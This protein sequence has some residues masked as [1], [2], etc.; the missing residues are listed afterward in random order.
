MGKTAGKGW[1]L[2]SR[3]AWIAARWLALLVVLVGAGG[4]FA[5]E[6]GAEGTPPQKTLVTTEV[7]SLKTQDPVSLAEVLSKLAQGTA[8]DKE[9]KEE[10]VVIASDQTTRS[11]IVRANRENQEWIAKLIARLDKR[12]PQLLIDVTMVEITNHDRFDYDLNF[13]RNSAGLPGGRGA[14]VEL[15]LPGRRGRV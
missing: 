7:Y 9:G 8:Q 14:S 5:T 6:K 2:E 4:A 12:P 11:V 3:R 10:K 1:F 15:H 13:I